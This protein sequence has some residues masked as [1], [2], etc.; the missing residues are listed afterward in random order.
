MK[1]RILLGFSLFALSPLS[2][3]NDEYVTVCGYTPA[4][5]FQEPEEITLTDSYTY[6]TCP[7]NTLVTVTV[8]R[9][10]VIGLSSGEDT[11]LLSQEPENQIWELLYELPGG[12]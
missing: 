12:Y 10:I 1:F 11:I 8:T 9:R 4:D 7:P 6:P 3:A 5:T 2:M